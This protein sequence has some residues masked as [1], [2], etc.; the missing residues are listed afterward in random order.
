MQICARAQ[1][2]ADPT[3]A[4]S[5][6]EADFDNYFP[7]YLANGYFSTMTGLRGT[8]GEL[9]YMVGFMDYGADD[10]SRPA[11]IPGWSEIDYSTGDSAAGHFWLNQ[12]TVNAAQFSDY[13]QTLDMQEATL[14]TSYRY[15]DPSRQDDTWLY[16]PSLR[17]V[18]R[19]DVEM[20]CGASDAV[21][22]LRERFA[23]WLQVGGDHVR[24][25][26][27]EHLGD[28]RADAARG[29]CDEC[30]AVSPHRRAPIP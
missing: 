16:L 21:G 15:L 29:T 30:A 26:A 10:M 2:A 8:E 18:R 9:A 24:S 25:V 7:A 12:A 3:F 27:R 4:L 23:C 5:A 20:Q 22:H 28:R 1:A 13:R 6:S 19:C 17:R 11:A 14:T